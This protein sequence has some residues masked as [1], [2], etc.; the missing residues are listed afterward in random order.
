MA[1]DLKHL[2]AEINN[3][4]D[5]RDWKKFHNE[6]DLALSIVLESAELLE[7][8]QWRT[9]EE[10]TSQKPDRLAE[11]LADILIYGLMLADNLG[12][13]PVA[14]MRAKIESNRHKYPVE[15]AFGSNTKY[16]ELGD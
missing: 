2:L 10:T 16:D 14:I 13:D 15:K 9:A 12:L 6:K 11:E 7:L 4:R 5:E 3:F 1:D 8:F